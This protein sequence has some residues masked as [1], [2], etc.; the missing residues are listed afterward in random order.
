MEMTVRRL[1]LKPKDLPNTSFELVVEVE[2]MRGLMMGS[3]YGDMVRMAPEERERADEA[4]FP[5]QQV[6]V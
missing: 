6:K 4:G 2:L 1:S 3:S 5:S